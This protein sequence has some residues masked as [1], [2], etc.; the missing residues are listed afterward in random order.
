MATI[1]GRQYFQMHF[2]E[3]KILYFDK[4]KKT[5]LTFVPKGPI[6]IEPALV[7]IMVWHRNATSETMMTQFTEAIEEMS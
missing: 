1:F 2:C 6:D 7:Q 5:P 3:W 4:K